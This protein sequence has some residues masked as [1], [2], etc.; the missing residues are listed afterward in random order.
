MLQRQIERD[1][2][3]W[4]R[5]QGVSICVYWPLMKGLLTGKFAREHRFA[6]GDGR[7]KY[8]AYQGREWERN[9]DLLDEL[10][11]IAAETGCTLAQLVVHWTIS[12]PGITAALCGAKR[13]EQI[14]ETAAA[15]HVRLN[16]DQHARLSAALARRG[17][18][19]V[20]QAV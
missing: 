2:L 17:E 18:P 5:Q 12:Q 7:L 14:E 15:M 11:Q 4:C 9:H 1:T 8:P 10:R 19:L 20:R 16:A 6:P 3:P 13:P